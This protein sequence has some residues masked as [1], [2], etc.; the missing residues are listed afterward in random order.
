MLFISGNEGHG[1]R[2]NILRRCTQLVKIPSMMS[3]SAESNN[4]INT[5]ENNIIHTSPIS[6]KEDLSLESLI[7][8][9]EGDNS[10]VESSNLNDNSSNEDIQDDAVDSLNVS[11]TGGIIL[12]HILRSNRP[13]SI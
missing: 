4:N 13:K 2:T 10:D 11:V 7:E 6:G 12:H 9:S 8:G 5:M 3:M 1:I